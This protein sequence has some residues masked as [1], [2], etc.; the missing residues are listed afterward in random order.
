MTD[1]PRPHSTEREPGPEPADTPIGATRRTVMAALGG[2]TLGAAALGLTAVQATAAADRNS[3]AQAQAQAPAGPAAD[4]VL[5]PEQTEGPYYL[6]LETVRKN[7]TEGKPGVP[8][9]L[10]VKVID[11]TTCSPL[12][13]TA[14]DIWHCDALGVYS[15]YVA[16]GST[17]DT[18]FLRGVQL[19]DSTGV[20]EFTTIYP[21]WY[22]GRALHI[23]VKTHVGGTVTGGR[24]QG[25]HVSHTG[26][27]YFPETYNS[28]VATLT[29]YRNNTATRTLNA[30]DGIYR[31]GGSSTLLTLTQTGSDLGKGVTGTVVLGIDPDAVP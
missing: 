31:N 21:G 3:A 20:A 8:L 18:T 24:Y 29:P 9:T 13:G 15:G 12:P 23:H 27:L 14:V 26:Q 10:R 17:P 25:G 19:T 1:T 2:T 5:T 4:C 28:R 22:V 30:R 7:I 6:D 16:G 11:T